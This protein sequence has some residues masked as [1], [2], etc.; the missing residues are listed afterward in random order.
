MAP[1]TLTSFNKEVKY[2]ILLRI[3]AQLMDTLEK[4]WLAL[5]LRD[6]CLQFIPNIMTGFYQILL[7]K[8]KL[9]Y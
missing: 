9:D 2:S 5:M 7:K 1:Y 6:S 3:C 4:K 8:E